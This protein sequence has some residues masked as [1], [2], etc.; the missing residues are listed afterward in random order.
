LVALGTVIQLALLTVVQVAVEI[1]AVTAMFPVA[2]GALT[3]ADAGLS[4][5]TAAPAAGA[6]CMML[7]VFPATVRVP[8]RALEV[9]GA[10]E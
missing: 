4:E 2:A 10:T 7:I 8:D 6:N 9:F 3:L 1:E 5:N